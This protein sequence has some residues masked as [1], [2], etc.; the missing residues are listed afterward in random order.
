MKVEAFF[1]FDKEL[2]VHRR[3]EGFTARRSFWYG[4]LS[5]LVELAA[6]L[7]AAVVVLA[8]PILPFALA[9]AAGAMIFVVVEE[10]IPE[11]QIHGNEDPGASLPVFLLLPGWE[12]DPGP[13]PSPF[14][15]DPFFP[16]PHQYRFMDTAFC[17]HYRGD[18]L[19]PSNRCCRTCPKG[20]EAC[21]LLWQR[22]LALAN[23]HCGEAVPLAG[24]RAVMFPHKNP[25]FVRLQVNVRWNLPKED[26]LHFIATGHA[27]MGRKGRRLDPKSSPSMTRQEPY[28]QAILKAV[29]GWDAPE[30][31]AV[32]RVQGMPGIPS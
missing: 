22:V 9:F 12:E 15:P 31:L 26:F 21:D 11:P 13:L 28:V 17:R 6:L 3:A 2:R 20:G 8:K 27:G 32:K 1:L 29:G 5:G 7:G 16:L 4:R 23:S 30:V 18:G 10:L 14:R 19:P 24:T 25:H